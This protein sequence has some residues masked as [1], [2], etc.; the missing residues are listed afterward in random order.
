MYEYMMR[1]YISG[2]YS[3]KCPF[4]NKHLTALLKFWGELWSSLNLKAF[5]CPLK[6]N[7]GLSKTPSKEKS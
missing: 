3:I 6:R 7:F 5:I 1:Q 4:Y 2:S